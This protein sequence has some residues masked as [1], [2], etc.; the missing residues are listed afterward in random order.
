MKLRAISVASRLLTLGQCVITGGVHCEGVRSTGT[1]RTAMA[2]LERWQAWAAQLDQVALACAHRVLED[3]PKPVTFLIAV[4]AVFGAIIF[5][6]QMAR[7][8]NPKAPPTFEGIPLIGGILKFAKVRKPARRWLVMRS[9]RSVH[10]TASS[11]AA[12]TACTQCLFELCLCITHLITPSNND[13]PVTGADEGDGGRLRQ[14]RRGVH[15]AAAALQP[16]LPHRPHRR[17][18]LLQSHR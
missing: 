11:Q 3:L 18:A 16:D 15:G 1:A 9:A 6:R 2:F 4:F 8:M 10:L 17:A 7:G 5:G 13:L 14:L 12:V